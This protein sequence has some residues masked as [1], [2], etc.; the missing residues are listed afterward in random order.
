MHSSTG[1]VRVAGVLLAGALALFGS[2][3]SGESAVT[4]GSRAAGMDACVAPT[5]VMR[6][7]H[8]EF[9][10]HDRVDIVHKGVR[11]TQYSLAGCIDCHASRDDEG[12]YHPVNGEGQFCS[13]CHEYVAVSLTCFQCHGKKPDPKQPSLGMD[14]DRSVDGARLGLLPGGVGLNDEEMN[15]LHAIS[16][17]VAR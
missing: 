1:V 13:S 7:N 16:R 17:E 3:A 8:M 4:P 12:G 2:L 9:L 11:N 10:K 14:S 15:E 6:R 5:D